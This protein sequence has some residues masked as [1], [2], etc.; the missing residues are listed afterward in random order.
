MNNRIPIELR[1]EAFTRLN[2]DER[3]LFLRLSPGDQR[4]S[5]DVY[6]T[7]V[8][9]WPN[10]TYLHVAGLLHDVGKGRPSLFERIAFSL[11]ITFAPWILLR[12]ENKPRNSAIG[13]IGNLLKHTSDSALLAE[14]AG[15]HPA[16]IDA[17]KSYGFRE[18]K[19]GCRLA[20]LDAT[21]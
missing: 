13:R 5:L 18:H 1:E 12:W 6:R 14:L 3:T 10:D 2:P 7:T 19:Q 8:V 9:E 4:H 17:I 15:S 11:L 20:H 16:V 21:L